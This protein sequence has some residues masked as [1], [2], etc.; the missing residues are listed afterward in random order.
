[1]I[2][3]R[4]PKGTFAATLKLALFVVVPALALL[5][6]VRVGMTALG[7]DQVHWGQWGAAFF[8]EAG[9]NLVLPLL[10]VVLAGVTGGAIP[11]WNGIR[12]L[13][14]TY[15]NAA[16]KGGKAALLGATASLIFPLL[17]VWAFP[18]AWTHWATWIA[19]GLVGCLG[20]LGHRLFFFRP[21]AEGIQ[22][23]AGAVA[24]CALAA[25]LLYL[26]RAEFAPA[27]WA[28][29]PVSMLL[30]YVLATMGSE[31]VIALQERRSGSTPA[32]SLS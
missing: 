29:P 12:H 25:T 32:D 4:P 23:A 28:L 13:P 22:Q 21:R 16:G 30:P 15:A 8:G 27:L 7:L 6:T 10:L 24:G 20:I 11:V 1:M 31:T 14:D 5:A 17:A 2:W 26:L 19:A 18:G 9:V 3:H